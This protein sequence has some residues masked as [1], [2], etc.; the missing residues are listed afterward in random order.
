MHGQLLLLFWVVARLPLYACMPVCLPACL[1]ICLPICLS[2]CLLSVCFVFFVVIFCS[3][4]QPSLPPFCCA[5]SWTSGCPITTFFYFTL[6]SFHPIHLHP[7][8][9]HPSRH[10]L[11]NLVTIKIKITITR[12]L[13]FSTQID[14]Y[15]FVF[16]SRD[17]KKKHAN[18]CSPEKTKLVFM[19]LDHP[20]PPSLPSLFPLQRIST[21]PPLLAPFLPLSRVL[22]V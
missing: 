12:T 8:P 11:T 6:Y 5:H 18:I 21:I 3:H 4:A 7:H 2:L 13:P 1:P 17:K 14:K 15:F 20:P 19:K 22:K 9:H 10:L 16:C